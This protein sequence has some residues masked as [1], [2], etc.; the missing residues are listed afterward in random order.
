MHNGGSNERER[1]QWLKGRVAKEQTRKKHVVGEKKPAIPQP[2]TNA[3]A[4]GVQAQVVLSDLRGGDDRCVSSCLHRS[5]DAIISS[6]AGKCP[7]I[8]G[9][10][11]IR[12]ET[13]R[14]RSTASTDSFVDS[15]ERE[16]CS[17]YDHNRAG[18][19]VF[20]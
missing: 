20:I 18:I 1:A 4:I 14:R 2:G 16:S 9:A 3:I 15:T 6:C 19:F 8:D 11:G 17:N 7:G 12:R 5:S 13:P 10:W